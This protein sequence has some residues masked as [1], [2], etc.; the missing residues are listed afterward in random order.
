MR[1][2]ARKRADACAA[3]S[4]RSSRSEFPATGFCLGAN[5]K[6]GS[7]ACTRSSRQCDATAAACV[8]AATLNAPNASQRTATATVVSLATDARPGTIDERSAASA[9]FKKDSFVFDLV[10]DSRK[11][12][13]PL[14][15]KSASSKLA[16]APFAP[17]VAASAERSATVAETNSGSS[18]GP[19]DDEGK[20]RVPPTAWRPDILRHAA[21]AAS[22]RRF[23]GSFPNG[24]ASASAAHA[25][26]ALGTHASAG[27]EA[28][29]CVRAPCVATAR[30][31]SVEDS[32]AK[33]TRRKARPVFE[34]SLVSAADRY[35]RDAGASKS[36]A[37]AA[38]A[39]ARA[40]G[41]GS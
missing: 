32:D 19:P 36:C 37:T 3:R 38:A 21:S 14:S 29:A 33:F 40:R 7:A 41:D 22:G 28:T 17:S 1:N 31:P 6:P 23:R 34:S 20:S 35:W 16:G 25:L 10:I 8:A 9:G 18:L 11:T 4:W 26:H 5:I 39:A 24:A 2:S 12:S 27:S 15:R 30:S 13:S